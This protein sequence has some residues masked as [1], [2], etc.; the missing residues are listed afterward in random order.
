MSFLGL[1]LPGLGLPGSLVGESAGTCFLAAG[2][3]PLEAT[4]WALN[5]L[6][7]KC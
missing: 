1:H 5:E 2:L 7:L 6:Q 4:E 3:N